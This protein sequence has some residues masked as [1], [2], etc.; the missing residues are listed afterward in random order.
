ML[1]DVVIANMALLPSPQ[2]VAGPQ[3]HAAPGPASGNAL[4][5]GLMQVLAPLVASIWSA[6]LEQTCILRCCE[7]VAALAILTT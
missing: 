3:P 5:A 1:T 7:A 4:L 2:D 6:S